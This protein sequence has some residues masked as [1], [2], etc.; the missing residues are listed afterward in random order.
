MQGSL[1]WDLMSIGPF[2]FMF[3][4]VILII[5]PPLLSLVYS[6]FF[7]ILITNFSF[8]AHSPFL[9]CYFFWL[10]VFLFWLLVGVKPR[11][12]WTAEEH[13]NMRRLLEDFA[14]QRNL[15]PLSSETWY[16][17]LRKFIINQ[18][19]CWIIRLFCD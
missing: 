3:I 13:A 7:H 4:L 6:I 1:G 12:Y 2:L 19:V 18:N 10:I 16:S 8:H 5:I 17:I 11:G 9:F 15:D 14:R